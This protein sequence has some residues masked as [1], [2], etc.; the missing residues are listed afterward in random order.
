MAEEAKSMDILEVFQQIIS[1]LYDQLPE[2]QKKDF[3]ENFLMILDRY[4][5]RV[6]LRGRNST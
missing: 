2:D 1:I 5:I 3:R 4:K 6:D